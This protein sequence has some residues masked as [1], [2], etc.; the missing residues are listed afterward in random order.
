MKVATED[1]GASTCTVGLWI[2]AGSRYET[3]ETN[4]VAHFLEHMIFKG[5]QKRSQNA[6]ELEVENMGA[7]L[8]AY[9]SR[10]QTVYYA[11]CFSKDLGKAVDILSDITQNSILGEDEIER[12]RGVI[13]REMQD[14]EQNSQEVVFDYLHATAYQGTSLGR[15]ILG[16]IKNIQSLKKTD[17]LDYIKTHYTADRIVLAGAGGVDHEKLVDLAEQHFGGLPQGSLKPPQLAP[18]R[19]TGSDLREREDTMPFAHVALSV[20]GT[21]WDNPESVALMVANT[22]IGSW[23]RSYGGSGGMVMNRLGGRCAESSLCHSYQAFNTCYSDTGLWGVYYV[24]ELK[25][26]EG[27]MW[28]I[29]DEWLHWTKSV[30]DLEID[31]AK[32]LLKTNLQLQLDGTTPICE[33]IGRQMLCYGRRIPMDEM[34]ARVDCLSGDDVR[35]VVYKYVYDKCPSVAAIGPIEGLADYNR[36]KGLTYWIRI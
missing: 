7:H 30:P 1:T 29:M 35:S 10:E 17:L 21:A 14:V 16:P 32:R 13:L 23:D 8:N 22:G 25:D 3:A 33:D 24:A 36:I 31:R 34:E 18:A 26:V 4:G 2:N 9:T 27:M 12:E 11:K 6:L 20:E 28:N 15:T 5:T 19:Y